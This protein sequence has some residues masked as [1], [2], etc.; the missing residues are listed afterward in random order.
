MF[1]WGGYLEK[2]LTS[3]TKE[4]KIANTVI[5]NSGLIQNNNLLVRK[6][7]F[8]NHGLTYLKDLIDQENGVLLTRQKMTEQLHINI[9][10][11]DYIC[12]VNSIPRETKNIIRNY[13]SIPNSG[14]IGALVSTLCDKK[15]V[16]R[17]V[18]KT[19]IGHL[20]YEIKSKCKWE[21]IIQ[22]TIESNEMKNIFT[23]P[24]KI[25]QHKQIFQYKIIHRILPTNDLL[26]TYKIR[27]NPY[28]DYCPNS[29]DKIEHLLHLC[30]NTLKLWYDVATWLL[31]E[32]VLYPYI[33]TQN[34]ML[35]ILDRNK[36]LENTLI[37]AIKRY[38]Y[39]CKCKK[40]NINLNGTIIY[41]QNLRNI[42]I[43]FQNE[44]LQQEYIIKWQTIETKILV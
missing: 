32:I 5:W 3:L 29:I 25:T 17:F 27:D 10:H 26:H 39:V 38:I 13:I 36:N 16:C 28:C 21:N 9:S 30:T 19:I 44:Q 6:N 2:D 12:L 35:G 41:L 1:T 22:Q 7:D 15:K 42:E 40:Q 18:Y 14:D 33:N 8:I 24:N 37:L 31:P 34:I 43:K 20:P 11:F 23:L 4:Q